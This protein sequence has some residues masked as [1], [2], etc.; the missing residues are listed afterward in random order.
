[1]VAF[2]VEALEVWKLEI[3]PK[4]DDILPDNT[5]NEL[6][7]IFVELVLLAKI[8]V[9]VIVPKLVFVGNVIEAELKS[10]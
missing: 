2:T 5:F 10:S 3:L 8:F 6:A 9:A 1:M 4:R 7:K